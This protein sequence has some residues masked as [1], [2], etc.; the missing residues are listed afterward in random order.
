MSGVIQVEDGIVRIGLSRLQMLFAQSKDLMDEI[1]ASMLVS[2]R[3]TF[4]EQGSP[5]HSWVPLAPSTIRSNPKIYGAGHLILIRS[6]RL[7]NSITFHST[8]N[9]VVIGTNLVYAAVHQFGSRDRSFGIGPRTEEQEKSTIGVKGTWIGPR[10]Q[11]DAAEYYRVSAPL[12]YGKMNGSRYKIRG[13]RNATMR[14]IRGH[15][16]YVRHQ[17]IPA[18]PYVVFRPEDP[19]RIRGLVAE[20]VDKQIAEAGLGGAQ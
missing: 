2:I 8:R 6:S 12:G 3:R 4:R 20:Y 18:R 16:A 14:G 9:T 17:N 5:A 7:L 1:G 15:G 19:E 11:K 10:E 13:P